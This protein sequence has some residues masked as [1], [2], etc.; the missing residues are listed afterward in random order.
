MS[1]ADIDEQTARKAVHFAA[2]GGIT[3]SQ[4]ATVNAAAA[5]AQSTADAIKAG[6]ATDA[7]TLLEVAGKI[8]S[9]ITTLKGS[10]DVSG[11]TLGE[12]EALAAAAQSAVNAVTA[13]TSGSNDTLIEVFNA[14]ASQ[15]TTATTTLKGSATTAGDTLG[16]LETRIASLE[17]PRIET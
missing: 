1:Q 16:E 10:A 8:T 13:G 17:T 3:G 9:A 4:L 15:I 12:L 14:I 7:D 11:D 6:A 2:A 5:A